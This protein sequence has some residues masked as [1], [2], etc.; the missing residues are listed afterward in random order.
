MVNGDKAGG[1][2]VGVPEKILLLN[3]AKR[4]GESCLLARPVLWPK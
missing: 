2:E 3:K 1:V 4:A